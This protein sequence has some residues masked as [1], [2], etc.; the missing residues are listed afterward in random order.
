MP[1]I[2][3]NK[4]YFEN[5][6]LI[7]RRVISEFPALTLAS[8]QKD[9]SAIID[10][11]WQNGKQPDFYQEMF[12]TYNENLHKAISNPDPEVEK[13]LK[14]NVTRLA[15]AKAN[16]ITQ[17][18]SDAKK[19]ASNREEYD[20][21]AQGIINMAN[22]TQ[23]AEYNTAV[24]RNR[25]VKQWSQFEKDKRLLP[26][27]EW[28][29]T[30]SASPREIH[31]AYVGRI[32][33]MND[34]FWK[35]NHPGCVYNC[36]CDWKN[37][38]SP[39][40]DNSGVN[41][42]PASPG[43]EGN[44]FY[45]GE[46]YSEKHPYF[47][48]VDKHIPDLGVLQNTDEIVY[49]NKTTENGK[50]FKEHYLCGFEPETIENRKI[51]NALLKEDAAMDIKLLPQIHAS[52]AE[53]RVRYYGKQY[54]ETHPTKC[55][56]CMADGVAF[57]FKTTGLKR[58]SDNILKASRQSDIAVIKLTTSPNTDWLK[59]FCEKQF[60]L[61]DRDNLK[62]IIVLIEDTVYTYTK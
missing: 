60:T 47:D 25:I 22:S 39:A 17:Q 46:I 5:N 19:T 21:M 59:R 61:S 44:P 51:V 4:L 9:L 45:T 37:T 52:E 38:D 7:K 31:L 16:Y 36:K 2:D 28:L 48:R 13:M 41:P 56:D 11:V 26:N 20:R 54:A 49:L 43:L 34:P 3:F 62:K 42:V 27:I 1:E 30:R 12:D 6:A 29:H 8:R 57:E 33:P 40:T 58:F 50:A 55:P 14:N 23:A 24:H 15:A 53:L 32:W 35:D 10:K 18:L